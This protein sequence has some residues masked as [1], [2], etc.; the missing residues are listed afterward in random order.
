MASVNAFVT[1]LGC[2]VEETVNFTETKKWKQI[3]YVTLRCPRKIHFTRRPVANDVADL[4][5]QAFIID[6]PRI[7]AQISGRA[8]L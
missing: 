5:A 7:V 2:V 3:H 1:E 8:R 4:L 6:D